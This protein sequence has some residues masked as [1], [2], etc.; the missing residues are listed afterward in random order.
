MKNRRRRSGDGRGGRA[1]TD[2]RG[3]SALYR[4]A[5]VGPG[6]TA[7]WPHVRVLFLFSFLILISFFFFFIECMYFVLC[8]VF[9]TLI[10]ITRRWPRMEY[11]CSLVYLYHAHHS[12]ISGLSQRVHFWPPFSCS[13]SLVLFSR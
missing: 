9:F 6:S 2:I 5:G 3:A 10:F 11:Y 12:M 13:F 1:A 7:L 4:A 8:S